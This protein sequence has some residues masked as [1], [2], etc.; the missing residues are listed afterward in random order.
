MGIRQLS[1]EFK[2]LGQIGGGIL[3]GCQDEDLLLVGNSFPR[4]LDGVQVD[5]LYRG[6][7]NLERG[8]VVK[9][10]GRLRVRVPSCVLV[11]RHVYRRLRGSPAVEAKKKPIVSRQGGRGCASGAITSVF[12]MPSY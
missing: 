6:R 2:V 1:E 3:E 5:V 7:V 10:D 12:L 4:R 9:D 11:L 8:V